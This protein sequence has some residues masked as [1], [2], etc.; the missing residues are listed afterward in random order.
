[1]SASAKDIR[2]I[3]KME[4]LKATEA[5]YLQQGGTLNRS[6]LNK[7]QT[8]IMEFTKSIERDQSMKIRKLDKEYGGSS[9][10]SKMPEK[11]QFEGYASRAR[12][13]IDDDDDISAFLGD[14]HKNEYAEPYVERKPREKHK[15]A[16]D[17]PHIDLSSHED[18]MASFSSKS[19]NKKP[20]SNSKQA[21]TYLDDT[22]FLAQFLKSQTKTKVTRTKE[23]EK[24]L[25][26]LLAAYTG[27]KNKEYVH[28]IPNVICGLINPANFCY[29]NSIIQCLVSNTTMVR[30]IQT[31][32][33]KSKT[34]Y[35]SAFDKFVAEISTQMDSHD[36]INLNVLFPGNPCLK[37]N[38]TT[39]FDARGNL[40][41]QNDPNEYLFEMLEDNGI[42][43]DFM[44]CKTSFVKKIENKFGKVPKS[45]EDGVS[46]NRLCDCP[47]IVNHC[48][49]GSIDQTALDH[50]TVEIVENSTQT[51]DVKLTS[52][53]N[54]LSYPQFFCVQTSGKLSIPITEGFPLTE[55]LENNPDGVPQLS[56]Y[57]LTSCVM[58]S[59]EPCGDN[60]DAK[61]NLSGHYVAC[62]KKN[63]EW[64]VMVIIF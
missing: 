57:E 39:F 32:L 52:T 51:G 47:K 19:H 7:I 25:D 10:K 9:Y 31:E 23:E 16:S 33:G 53:Y 11:R 20:K 24:E 36:R 50:V 3:E 61:T 48:G 21:E 17:M 22:E 37:Y 18:F 46:Y 64:F 27:K 56:R 35:I 44:R 13:F 28:E 8:Q 42:I 59:G 34:C 1:M 54:I 4:L 38:N 60:F 5:S 63:N 43:A 12:D 30:K 29:R 26:D 40:L 55:V 58:R 2:D 62:V 41:T 49:T 6:E 14:L 15:K 45:S